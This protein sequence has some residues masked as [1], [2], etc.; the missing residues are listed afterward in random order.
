MNSLTSWF[1][2]V[3]LGGCGTGGGVAVRTLDAAPEDLLPPVIK[4]AGAQVLEIHWSPPSKP[5]GLITSYHI[6]RWD[7]TLCTFFCC[8]AAVQ[9]Y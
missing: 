5:N 2:L 4:A 1:C 3:R 9:V 8:N 7:V 6:Y